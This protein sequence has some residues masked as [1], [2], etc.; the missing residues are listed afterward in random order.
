MLANTYFKTCHFHFVSLFLF[1]EAVKCEKLVIRQC[2]NAGYNFTSVS[3]EYQ[4]MVKESSAIFEGSD[5]NSML[6]KIICMEI[7]PP[8]D[9]KNNQTLQ[10]PCKSTCNE[11]F[12]ESR[13][14]FLKVFKA[15]EYCSAFPEKTTVH[16]NE[17]CSIQA[18]PDNGYWPSGLWTS[19]ATAGI[20]QS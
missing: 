1:A 14:A 2:Q 19:L 6:R 13:S 4:K 11:A 10:V 3:N 8:C 16:G 20:L 18:W 12:N 17:Y 15:Q 7:A 9:A 5:A